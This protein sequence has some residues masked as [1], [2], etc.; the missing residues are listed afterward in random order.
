MIYLLASIILAFR[1]IVFQVL[2]P[3]ITDLRR[4]LEHVVWKHHY[5][6]KQ[7][8][9]KTEMRETDKNNRR[10]GKEMLDQSKKKREHYLCI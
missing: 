4:L 5:D 3:W 8:K 7:Q 9:M 6:I 2:Y 10:K 1:A